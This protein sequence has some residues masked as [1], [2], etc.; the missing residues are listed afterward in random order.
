M[1][2]P[3]RD[4]RPGQRELAE[5]V[6]R[7]V[8]EGR[9]LVVNA[10][11]GFGKTAAVIQGLLDAGAERVLWGVR[12]VNEVDP[13]IREL[14]AFGV[15][16][17]FLFS[18]RRTCPLIRTS[19]DSS[20][21][22]FWLACRIARL[23]GE[24][25]YYSRLEDVEP[26]EVWDYVRSH[27]SF[28]GLVLARDLAKYLGV[29]PFFA[30]RSLLGEA[31]VAVVTYPYI[32][33]E[34]IRESVLDPFQLSDFVLVVDEAH[35]LLSAH[36]LEERDVR[37]RDLAEAAAEAKA[38]GYAEI[39]RELEEALSR[40]RPRGRVA[41]PRRLD[42]GEVL[43][44]LLDAVDIV[45]DAAEEVAGRKLVE[46]VAS[47][48][49]FRSPLVRVAKWLEHAA[50][51]HVSVFLDPGSGEPV[52]KAMPVDPA[53]VARPVLEAVKAAVLMSG[54][55]PPSDFVEDV[56][57]VKKDRDL[58]D[59]RLVV[60]GQRRRYAA[61]V[62]RDV[63]SRYS[64]RSPGMYRRMAEYVA[65]VARM[66][67]GVKL[68]VYPS[69]E[70]LRE[71]ASRIPVD[72]DQVVEDERTSLAEV[73]DEIARREGNL[74]VHAVAGGKLVEGVE[75]TD[76]EGRSLLKAVVVVGVP[77]PQP[78][79]YTQS[80]IEALAARLGRSKAKYYVY[81][82][83]AYVKVGQAL[84]RAI[85]GPGDR[86]VYVLLDYRYLYSRLRK[87]LRLK[88]DAVVSSPDELAARLPRLSEALGL[89]Q[90]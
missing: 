5:A 80:L 34:D 82:V 50:R 70:V 84:G 23:R 40:A 4:Y 47:G 55:M 29:C 13:V 14:K 22:E 18:A 54:T 48:S 25:P 10:P 81:D 87:L 90:P 27:V 77:Y 60:G 24:C 86:A 32:F 9:L 1:P 44:G 71:V 20:A 49:R 41:A 68:A 89:L 67:P 69:Y 65:L 53:D 56:L 28:H 21:E 12:T 35:S 19:E 37:L 78:D 58:F 88:Y 76:Y 11:T 33:R 52:L 57:G 63:T 39:A 51:R 26:D 46:A 59:A 31:T 75:F 45:R 43:G 6:A 3:Y 62:A 66:V 15:K 85:R 30:L 38:Y 64:L 42:K 61:V 2:F 72:V 74:L 16:F 73:R 7:A 79:A 83:Q 17:T 36:Q 8:S